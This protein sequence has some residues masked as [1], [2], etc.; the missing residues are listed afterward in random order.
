MERLS[1]VNIP[2][3]YR[4]L[5]EKSRSIFIDRLNGRHINLF[6]LAVAIIVLGIIV[7]NQ[8]FKKVDEPKRLDIVISPHSIS[9]F[10][11]STINALIQEFEEQNPGLRIQVATHD[12]PHDIVFFDDGEF[13]DLIRDSY[14]HTETLVTFMDVFIYNIDILREANTDRPPKTRAEFL[15]VAKAIKEPA[16]ALGLGLHPEDPTALRRDFYPWVWVSGGDIHSIDLSAE[17]PALPRAI[18]DLVAFFGQLDREGLLAPGTFEKTSAQR[19]DDFAKGRTAMM[20]ASVRELA[21]LQQNA[22]GINFDITSV[23]AAAHGKNRLGLSGIYAGINSDSPLPDESALFLAFVAEKSHI[24]AETLGAVPGRFPS[25]S[26]GEYIAN[27]TL[28]SKAWDI[29]QMADI[30][31]YEFDPLLEEKINPIIRKKLAEALK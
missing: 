20:T 29:F 28:Y 19:L 9:L 25:T 14:I 12:V 17:D 24:L 21:Y 11:R 23:P 31:D 1:K 8:F 22:S 4:K 16:F 13:S 3:Y 26:S 5:I 15:A 18:T 6:L 27:D 30:V 7:A 2:N 10:G